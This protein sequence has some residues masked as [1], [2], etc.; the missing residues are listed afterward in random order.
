[1]GRKNSKKK[2]HKEKHRPSATGKV[3]K[4][5]LDITR[6]GIGYVPIEGCGKTASVG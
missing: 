5:V 1:M 4:G 6:S 2:S 3:L